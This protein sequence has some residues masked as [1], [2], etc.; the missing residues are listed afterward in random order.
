LIHALSEVAIDY[1]SF[2]PKARLQR[3][4]PDLSVPDLVA[5]VLQGDM[6]FSV[7]RNLLWAFFTYFFV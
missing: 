4:N 3:A 2:G 5:M 6:A 7:L 1:R